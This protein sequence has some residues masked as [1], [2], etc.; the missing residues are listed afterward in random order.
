MTGMESI[1]LSNIQQAVDKLLDAGCNTVIITL[2]AS[3][4]VYASSTDRTAKHVASEKVIPI[5]T[6][7]NFHKLLII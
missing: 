4:A 3:G 5:D 2:G 1:S 7:V 6:T